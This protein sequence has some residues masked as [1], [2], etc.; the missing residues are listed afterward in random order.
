MAVSIADCCIKRRQS[1]DLTNQWKSSFPRGWEIKEGT[2]LKGKQGNS[3]L[4]W[5][6]CMFFGLTWSSIVPPS[7]LKLTNASPHE[8]GH[9]PMLKAASAVES[10][11]SAA[12]AC[13]FGC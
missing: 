7:A 13:L 3:S 1:L 12:C 4:Y 6:D 5:S 11:I 8:K 10:P 2:M 9:S